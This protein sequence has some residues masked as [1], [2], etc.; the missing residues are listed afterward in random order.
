MVDEL[1]DT[2]IALKLLQDFFLTL[3]TILGR[4][5]EHNL[6]VCRVPEC[7]VRDC[8]IVNT[9]GGL[10]DILTWHSGHGRGAFV[11]RRIRFWHP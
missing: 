2:R 7:V 6:F 3:Q 11:R 8:G 1:S 5:F 4:T 10:R 9:D